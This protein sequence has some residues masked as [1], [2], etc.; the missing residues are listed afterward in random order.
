MSDSGE[1]VNP[2]DLGGDDP[3]EDSV[4]SSNYGSVNSRT[5]PA[6]NTTG[7][8]SS[9]APV[10]PKIGVLEAICPDKY[11]A[12]SNG[13]PDHLWTHAARFL[14]ETPGQQRPIY[15]DKLY[16][17]RTQGLKE[18]FSKKEK[19]KEFER[20]LVTHFQNYGLYAIT[21]VP[22]MVDR[23]KMVSIL[24]NHGRF[25]SIKAVQTQAE[26]Q[27]LSYDNYDRSNDRDA[28]QFL[29]NSLN[30]TLEEDLA[31]RMEDNDCFPVVFMR[32]IDIIRSSSIVRLEDLKKQ[33]RE[34]V[35]SNYAGEN[36]TSMVRDILNLAKELDA[37]G[38]YDHTLTHA[39]TENLLAAGGENNEKYRYKL[40]QKDEALDDALRA[41]GFMDKSAADKFMKDQNL[42]FKDICNVAEKAYRVQADRNKWPPACVRPDSK[43]PP[44]AYGNLAATEVQTQLNALIQQ[45]RG[46]GGKAKPDDVCL[47]CG[48]KGHWARDC[49]SGKKQAKGKN[50]GGGKKGKPNNK[51]QAL[52]NNW[53]KVPPDQGEPE[54]KT[55]RGK[56]WHWCAHCGRWSTTH[57]T[58]DHTGPK[59]NLQT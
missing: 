5:D 35:A 24:S 9:F 34:I 18:K 53:K 47:N 20:K 40:R 45:Q 41:I 33:L 50:N 31:E 19:L 55:M 58:K 21:H 48:K 32:L 29:L 2:N 13:I 23:K 1:Q 56:T 3:S 52:T 43:A 7:G 27:L 15:N 6:A 30:D 12:R 28:I 10:K 51:N 16:E 11:I 37:A 8:S 26:V 14:P 38:Q 17:V 46:S 25:N 42:T 44:R 4:A 49:K 59:S 54:T 36:I 39:I 22:D 57:G